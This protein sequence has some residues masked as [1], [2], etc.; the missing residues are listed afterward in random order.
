MV[1]AFKVGLI[2]AILL[3]LWHALWAMLVA[4]GVAQMLLDFI[5]W[6]HFITPPYH[7][8]PFDPGRAGILIG[9]T[10]AIG[11]VGGYVGGVIRNMFHRPR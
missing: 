4:F 10:A 6:L 8:E 5:F 11:M 3:G 7:I 2:F 9:V 1:N